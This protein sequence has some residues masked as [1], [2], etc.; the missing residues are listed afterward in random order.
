MSGGSRK[1]MLMKP[2]STQLE[3]LIEERENITATREER[4]FVPIT[5]GEEE[6][7][8]QAISPIICEGDAIGS[9]I[10]TTKEPKKHFGETEQK[11]TLS[12]AGFLGKQMEN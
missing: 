3:N 7:Q 11:L 5:Q 1:D 2:I 8:A 9:V 6:F 12:A 4:R 10:I